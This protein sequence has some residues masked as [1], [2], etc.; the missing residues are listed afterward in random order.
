MANTATQLSKASAA[1]RFTSLVCNKYGD[2][3]KGIDITEKE[4]AIISGYF[5]CLDNA[6]AKQ[7]ITWNELDLNSLALDLAHK[8]RLGLDMQMKNYLAPAPYKNNKTGKITL[9][10]ITGYEGERHLAMKFAHNVPK[11]I[12]AELVYSTD[13][14][15]PIKKD[16][17]NPCDKYEFAITNPFDR[18]TIIGGFGYIEYED[19]TNNVLVVMPEK[20]ILKR[21]P[22]YAADEFWGKW[23]EKMYLKTIMKE[24]CRQISL[25]VDKVREYRDTFEYERQR[26]LDYAKAAADEEIT[27]NANKGEFV[28]V[29]FTPAGT[30][31]DAPRQTLTVKV[32]KSTGEVKDTPQN[33]Q[34]APQVVVSEKEKDT[35]KPKATVSKTEKVE[36]APES[37]D[38]LTSLGGA[39]PSL[40]N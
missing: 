12:R 39:E 2:V 7:N 17:N 33:A 31:A 34:S 22:S 35:E 26:E 10:L 30:N 21:K 5:I 11:D 23:R 29:D 1:E 36:T 18:G 37:D 3:A 38:F 16:H 19:S 32:D 6:L 24:T 25:D 13:K 15:I 9:T 40:F 4:K 8:A 14:F 27:A 20:D 28:D